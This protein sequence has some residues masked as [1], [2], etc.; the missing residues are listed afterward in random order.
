MRRII[1]FLRDVRG[2]LAKV[3]WPSRQQAWKMTIS[4][5][6]FSLVVAAFLGIVDFGLSKLIETIVGRL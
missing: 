3:I 1:Q 6:I 2:E 4:V 5:I